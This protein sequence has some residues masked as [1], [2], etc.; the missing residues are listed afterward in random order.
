[1][2][3][4][5]TLTL[6]PALDLSTAVDQ[7]VDAHKLR[8][9]EP[10]MHP[11]GGGVNVARVLAR[12]GADVLAVATAGG[13]TGER[14]T[15]LATAE[16]LRGAW[17]PI[18]GETRENF[19]VLERST[20]REL[21]FVLPGPRLAASEWQACLDRIAALPSRPDYLIASGSLPPG[22]PAD[23]YGRLA[24]WARRAGSRLL[25]DAS[26]EALASALAEGVWAIKPSLRELQGLSGRPLV[27][28]EDQ[29]EAA[30]LLVERG[31]A[32]QVALS[33]GPEGALAVSHEGAS[34]ARALQVPVAGTVGAGDSFVAGWVWGWDREGTLS[35][36]LREAMAA[37]A[38]ALLAPG[39]RLALAKDIERLRPDVAIDPLPHAPA[40]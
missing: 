32:Q 3:R 11:G 35:A 39:T 18:A 14:L 12:L 2:S 29:W 15:G 16:G 4:F 10:R 24:R 21:R 27:S 26:G 1:M 8:C 38:A 36:A 28:L 20:G 34:R 17:I 6:N 19:T 37:S 22:V 40:A 13:A 30:R 23:F 9:D 33:L 25:V 31:Q 5:V 7:V